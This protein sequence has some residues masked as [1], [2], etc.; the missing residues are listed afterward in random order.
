MFKGA[1]R[2]SISRDQISTPPAFP[3]HTNSELIHN[4]ENRLWL[5]VPLV[6]IISVFSVN[7]GITKPASSHKLVPLCQHL[8]SV[9]GHAQ[10]HCPALLFP[11]R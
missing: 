9:A 8:I 1:F 7:F 2:L 3:C 5:S 11:H 6:L 10:M 4:G